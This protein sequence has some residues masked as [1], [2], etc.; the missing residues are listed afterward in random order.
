MG[1]TSVLQSTEKHTASAGERCGHAKEQGGTTPRELLQRAKP[2]IC[3]HGNVYLDF[4]VERKE[5]LSSIISAQFVQL[6]C[7]SSVLG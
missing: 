7:F 4:W 2:H 1:C 5:V 6:I 3:K